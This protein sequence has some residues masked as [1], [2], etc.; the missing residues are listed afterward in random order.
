VFDDLGL[1]RTEAT[2]AK[3][4]AELWRELVGHIKPLKLTQK[5][6]ALRL[7]VHQPDVSHLL[8]GKL[9]KFSVGALIAYAVKLD[10]GVKV[11]ITAPARAKSGVVKSVRGGSKA[12]SMVVKG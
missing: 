11:S 4:K 8:N 5:E 9:S 1:S 7:D 12:D 2:E 3:V 6:L 10:L